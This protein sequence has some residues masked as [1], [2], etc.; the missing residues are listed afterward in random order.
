M[1]MTAISLSFGLLTS[2][3]SSLYQLTYTN[4]PRNH[5]LAVPT[6]KSSRLVQ[7]LIQRLGFGGTPS[8]WTPEWLAARFARSP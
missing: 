3:L 2:L 6:Q 8:P 5:T 4:I 1:G 7:V